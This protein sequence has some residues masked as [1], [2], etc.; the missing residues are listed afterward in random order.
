MTAEPQKENKRG[1]CD[2]RTAK[3]REIRLSTVTVDGFAAQNTSTQEAAPRMAVPA[4]TH[5]QVA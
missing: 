4:R 5:Q 1:F 2:C 3:L